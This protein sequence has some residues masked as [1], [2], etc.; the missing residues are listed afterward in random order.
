[1]D[2]SK[3]N[4][5]GQ[6]CLGQNADLDRI[7][8]F[9]RYLYMETCFNTQFPLQRVLH[10]QNTDLGYIQLP[11]SKICFIWDWKF[12][13][14]QG[15]FMPVLLLAEPSQ[16]TKRAL[17]KARVHHHV[18]LLLSKPPPNSFS[19][20]TRK[21]LPIVGSGR[22]FCEPILNG[23]SVEDFFF[24]LRNNSMV[25]V[26]RKSPLLFDQIFPLLS[27]ILMSVPIIPAC[28]ISLK[29]LFGSLFADRVFEKQIWNLHEINLA[30]FIIEILELLK[31]VAT[32]HD[33][34]VT[35]ILSL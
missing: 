35:R 28:E 8:C 1:M 11:V 17:V 25:F 29:H 7:W 33:F 22:L 3:T 26:F 30:D 31:S 19:L 9:L 34:N 16:L 13:G 23:L 2:H 6:Q 18:S 24:L 15:S 10:S 5:R 14:F 12:K 21:I 27:F 32:L 20:E 4:S